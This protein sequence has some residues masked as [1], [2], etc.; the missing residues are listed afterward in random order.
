[1]NLLVTEIMFVIFL[2][3]IKL[4]SSHNGAMTTLHL[5]RISILYNFQVLVDI[6]TVIF[7]YIRALDIA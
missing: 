5:W 2:Q 7:S 6:L 4:S 3:H 1:M